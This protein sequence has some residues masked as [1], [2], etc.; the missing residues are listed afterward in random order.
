MATQNPSPE[1][2]E[3][4]EPETVGSAY[5]QKDGTIEL[6]L[7]TVAS[8]GTIGEA[9]LAVGPDDERHASMVKHLGGIKPGEGRPIPPFPAEEG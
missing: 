1:T 6:S 5:M 3:D 7:R 8:D 9:M 4:D 2:P